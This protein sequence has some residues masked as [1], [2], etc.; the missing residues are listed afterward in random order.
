MIS[1]HIS[2]RH[3]LLSLSNTNSGESDTGIS[4][5]ILG[6]REIITSVA[7]SA[8]AS[9]VGV[10]IFVARTK[11]VSSA[12]IGTVL[13][14]PAADSTCGEISILRVGS[15]EEAIQTIASSCDKRFLQTIVALDYDHLLYRGISSDEPTSSSSSITLCQDPYDLPGSSTYDNDPAALKYFQSLENEML[16]NQ[17]IKPSTGHL[18]T[19]SPSDAAQWG[20]L[21]SQD[22]NIIFL[23]CGVCRHTY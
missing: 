19:T 9:A 13:L 3:R 18:A 16:K 11:T 8:S 2:N 14:E 22:V 4:R 12:S 7:A 10:G 5:G 1:G 23:L 17:P 6:R 15:M 21:C 20:V